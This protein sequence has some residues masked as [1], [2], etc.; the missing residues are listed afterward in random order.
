M[1]SARSAG[2]GGTGKVEEGRARDGYVCYLAGGATYF[3]AL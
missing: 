2:G 3:I 1:N